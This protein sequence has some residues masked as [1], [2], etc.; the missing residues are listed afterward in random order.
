MF[1]LPRRVFEQFCLEGMTL[2]YSSPDKKSGGFTCGG[3]STAIVVDEH[4]TLKISDKLDL[5]A[6]APLLCAGITTA[7]LR[8]YLLVEVGN[9]GEGRV[10]SAWAGSAHMG[11]KLAPARSGADNVTVLFHDHVDQADQA[12]ASRLGAG[13]E[14]VVSKNPDEMKPHAGSFD[15]I[16]D[17]VAADHDLNA[18]PVPAQARW[19]AGPRRAPRRAARRFILPARDSAAPHPHRLGHRR[20]RG[21]AGDARFLRRARVRLQ[22]RDDPDQSRSTRAYERVL[23]SDVKY[24]FIVDMKSLV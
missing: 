8:R 6:A 2:T 4:F 13:K 23:K 10:S 7:S 9:G 21:D 18:Y 1:Q 3:Y 12:L 17:T 22:H 16:L 19:Q 14:V 20:H 11:V 24:R 5:A 15:F